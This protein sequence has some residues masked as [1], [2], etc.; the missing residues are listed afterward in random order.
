MAGTCRPGE[1]G[2][3]FHLRS[4]GKP[5]EDFKQRQDDPR[6]VYAYLYVPASL[7]ILLF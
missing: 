7:K 5:L 2:H 3:G 6:V 4:S 1:P